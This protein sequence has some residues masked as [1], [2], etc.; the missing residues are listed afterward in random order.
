VGLHNALDS[1]DRSRNV[2]LLSG[3]VG[4][5]KTTLAE[6][7]VAK[8]GFRRLFTRDAILHRL[9]ETPRTRVDLQAAGERLDRETAGRWVADELRN[10]LTPE[11]EAHGVVVDA[12]LIPEQVDAIRASSGLPV[13]HVHLTAP[14]QVLERRYGIKRGGIKEAEQYTDLLASSTEANVD[15][16]SRIA[17]IVVDT[18]TTPLEEEIDRVVNHLDRTH[19]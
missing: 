8:R 14:R 5:G 7:L 3:P 6:A 19:Q 17:D 18:S 4:A 9:P 13:L 11:R 10:L 15:Q 16:L 12:V 2:V 1:A